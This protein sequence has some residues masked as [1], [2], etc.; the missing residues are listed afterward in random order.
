V[1]VISNKAVSGESMVDGSPP[2]FAWVDRGVAPGD[3]VAA[4]Y[5]ASITLAP[6]AYKLIVHADVYDDNDQQTSATAGFTK[7][8]VDVV[9][10]CAVPVESSSWGKIKS[11]YR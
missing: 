5:E 4:G 7:D 2:D 3:T 9:L 10:S 11:I 1:D 8:G 6:G